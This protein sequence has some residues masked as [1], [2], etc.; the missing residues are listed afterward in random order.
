MTLANTNNNVKI[1]GKLPPSFE[2]AVG[3]RREI[4]YPL[5]CSL[6]MEKIISVKINPPQG[7]S[8]LT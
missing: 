7:V 1:Q 2:T 6:G 8:T 5:S 4:H 3:L